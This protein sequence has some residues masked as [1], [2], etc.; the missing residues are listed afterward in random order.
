MEAG[1]RVGMAFTDTYGQRELPSGN[2][3]SVLKHRTPPVWRRVDFI[4]LLN[5][6]ESTANVRFSRIVLDRMGPFASGLAMRNA[7]TKRPSFLSV[8]STFDVGRV[9]VAH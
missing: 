3:G 2:C 6:W 4:L 5:G 9:E 8:V 7:S 1:N